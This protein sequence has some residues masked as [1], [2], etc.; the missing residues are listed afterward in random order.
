MKEENVLKHP[1]K[2][3]EKN[4]IKF[5]FVIFKP[6]KIPKNKEAKTFT[7]KIL[8]VVN[9]FSLPEIYF[10][11]ILTIKPKVLPAKI[12]IILSNSKL[13]ILIQPLLVLLGFSINLFVSNSTRAQVSFSLT[14]HFCK[15]DSEE[16]LLRTNNLLALILG[17]V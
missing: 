9:I 12:Q 10:I 7:I 8:L 11:N 4:N 17:K 16:P 15:T 6:K 13:Y 14:T 2:P 3:T 5:V 1:K